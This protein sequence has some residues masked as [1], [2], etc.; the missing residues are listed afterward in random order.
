V[1]SSIDRKW[2]KDRKT[3][4]RRRVDGVL[5]VMVFCP[6]GERGAS[7]PVDRSASL[8]NGLRAWVD[9]RMAQCPSLK[10]SRLPPSGYLDEPRTR[11]KGLLARSKPFRA[12]KQS[13]RG[14][15]QARRDPRI[16]S[17]PRAALIAFRI[18][19]N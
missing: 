8:N 14:G 15:L 10:G 1:F 2:I 19:G 18:A 4:S 11:S 17:H 13:A 5:P 9:C 6:T 16:R 12:R 3:Q 7:G